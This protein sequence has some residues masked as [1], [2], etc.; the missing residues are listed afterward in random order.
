M[1]LLN[2][3]RTDTPPLLDIRRIFKI[4]NLQLS[5]QSSINNCFQSGM[6][7]LSYLLQVFCL[8]IY[9]VVQSC[10]PVSFDPRSRYVCPC[11]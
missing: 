6:D 3:L 7:G 11:H 1:P 9:S 5:F 2:M 10:R 8:L 4:F